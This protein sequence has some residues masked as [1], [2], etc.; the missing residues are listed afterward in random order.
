MTFLPAPALLLFIGLVGLTGAQHVRSET[1]SRVLYTDPTE[2]INLC[3]ADNATQ[4]VIEEMLA[5]QGASAMA[6]T[7][8]FPLA[9]GFGDFFFSNIGNRPLSGSN[10]SNLPIPP[11]SGYT[12]R[13][14]WYANKLPFS[15][16][17]RNAEQIPG[18][19]PDYDPKNPYADQLPFFWHETEDVSTWGHKKFPAVPVCVTSFVGI[20]TGDFQPKSPAI[21]IFFK[22]LE[23]RGSNNEQKRQ[24]MSA[25]TCDKLSFYEAK[26]DAALD[27]LVTDIEA[28]G[29]PVLSSWL[30]RVITLFLDLHFGAVNHPD[31]VRQYFVRMFGVIS[32]LNGVCNPL[33]PDLDQIYSGF[34]EVEVVKEYIEERV[35]K[36][37]TEN[38]KSTFIF[39][40]NEA[41][42][43]KVSLIQEAVHNSL[44]FSQWV[45]TLYLVLAAKVQ[46]YL[47]ITSI[48]QPPVDP[49]PTLDLFA[50]YAQASTDAERINVAREC[51]RLLLPNNLWLSALETSSTNN[52]GK[53]LNDVTLSRSAASHIPFLIQTLSDNYDPETGGTTVS[54]YDTSRYADFDV[55]QTSCPFLKNNLLTL[56]DFSISDIDGET[57][58]P[59]GH[60]NLIPVFPSPKYCPFGLGYRRCPGEM[61]NYMFME[62]VLDKLGHLEFEIRGG[63]ILT[64]NDL[65]QGVS[66]GIPEFENA[67]PAG[68]V[69][70]PDDIYVKRCAT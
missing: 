30:D 36:I 62:K 53:A 45:N 64:P 7:W 28:R 63:A 21:S 16:D 20:P 49:P 54:T 60:E 3:K 27:D 24:Y 55:T 40:W 14:Q 2:R 22:N 8:I 32:N 57:V 1:S 10:A 70:R 11:D 37:I 47:A 33:D 43:P 59:A 58:I 34:C 4:A 61:L 69:R 51:F 29:K 46:G 6:S 19:P 52:T 66:S 17:E 26:V 65:A 12:E 56:E 13:Y 25:L 68:L 5:I 48:L 18:L 39:W 67:I 15:Y 41:G 9:D 50:A 31:Y 23:D 38:D 42:L 44:A 35:E